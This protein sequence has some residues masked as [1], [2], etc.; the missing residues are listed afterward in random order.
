MGTRL[1]RTIFT[2]G[3]VEGLKKWQKR[4]KRSL[5]NKPSTSKS[6]SFHSH[7]HGNNQLKEEEEVKSEQRGCNNG[8]SDEAIIVEASSTS[9]SSTQKESPKVGMKPNYDGEISF[10]RTWKQMEI[11]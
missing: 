1:K 10:A 5:S 4:S 6:T 11:N 2:D 3:I 7:S 8:D 9:Q